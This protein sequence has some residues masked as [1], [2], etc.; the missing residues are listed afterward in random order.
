MTHSLTAYFIH[1]AMFV[2]WADTN[3]ICKISSPRTAAVFSSILLHPSLDL[4]MPSI[5]VNR[6]THYACKKTL[7]K[8]S[9]RTQDFGGYVILER[10]PHTSALLKIPSMSALAFTSRSCIGSCRYAGASFPSATGT[11]A[12]NLVNNTTM[13][14]NHAMSHSKGRWWRRAHCFQG[15]ILQRIFPR[16][17]GPLDQAYPSGCNTC[18]TKCIS[19]CTVK[20]LR[21][22]PYRM[23]ALPEKSG[24]CAIGDKF[25]HLLE[26]VYTTG[27]ETLW[28]VKDKFVVASE[29]EFVLDVVHSALDGADYDLYAMSYPNVERYPPP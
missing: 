24:L 20:Q 2:S 18:P 5:L 9:I 4:C 19:K 28:I 17:V 12:S 26:F 10:R 25:L 14:T 29:N 1:N 27:F 3:S 23:K 22:L 8:P 13:G 16:T 11:S 15:Y 21:P 7:Y 6:R